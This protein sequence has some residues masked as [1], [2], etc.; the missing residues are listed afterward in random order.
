MLISAM[1]KSSVSPGHRGYS[2]PPEALPSLGGLTPQGRGV[3]SHPQGW[4]AAHE[5]WRER[6]AEK[7]G[8]KGLECVTITRDG[9]EGRNVTAV[10]RNKVCPQL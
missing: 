8:V 5:L 6:V 4:A 9:R 2:A 3:G 10:P 1:W 7:C